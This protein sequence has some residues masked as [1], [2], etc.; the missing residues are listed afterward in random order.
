MIITRNGCNCDALQLEA[1]RRQAMAVFLA[2]L[3]LRMRRNFHF[4]ASR[5]NTDTTLGIGDSDFLLRTDILVIGRQLSAFLPYFTAH[6]KAATSCFRSTPISP[7]S[8]IM[9]N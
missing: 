8:S 6:G 5:Q 2:V 3:L 7:R 1:V 4:R 9:H